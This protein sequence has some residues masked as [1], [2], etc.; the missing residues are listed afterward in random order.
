MNLD[1]GSHRFRD[2][3]VPLLW[4]SRAVIQDKAGRLSVIDLSGD[5][6]RLEV[7][8]DKAAPGVRYSPHLGGSFAVL[9]ARKEELYS[10]SP[11][12]KRLTTTRWNLPDCQILHDRILV[13][14]ST[15]GSNMIRNYGVGI[16]IS[17]DGSI[18]LGTPLP[19]GL[20]ELTAEAS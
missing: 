18:A 7:V 3:E 9:S 8:G 10:Y 15:F 4:G 14:A 16:R 19:P 6:A 2:V 5:K 1:M 17:E 12:E 20:A 13:G 11:E